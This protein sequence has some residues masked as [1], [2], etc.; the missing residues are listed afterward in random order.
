MLSDL[1]NRQEVITRLSDSKVGHCPSRI[2]NLFGASVF[3]SGATKPFDGAEQR[4]LTRVGDRECC[5]VKP[6]WFST[7]F[8]LALAFRLRANQG[9]CLPIVTP[10]MTAKRSFNGLKNRRLEI[11]F[12]LSVCDG[13]TRR[14]HPIAYWRRSSA[15]HGPTLCCWSCYKRQW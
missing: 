15:D 7:T 2:E 11:V 1:V 10:L 9:W 3:A 8:A 6:H 14:N 4:V 5:H 12:G 13:R